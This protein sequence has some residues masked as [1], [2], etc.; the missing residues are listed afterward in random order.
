MDVVST[1]C[2]VVTVLDGGRVIAE[3]TTAEI[4]RN[5]LVIKAYLGIADDTD[6][7]DAVPATA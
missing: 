7:A 1:L 3:G 6:I 2:D 4:K 5:P